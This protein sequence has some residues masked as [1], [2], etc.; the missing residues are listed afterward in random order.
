MSEAVTFVVPGPRIEAGGCG[1]PDGLKITVK[2]MLNNVDL[3][4]ASEA[5]VMG[6]LEGISR[7]SP[8]ALCDP[9]R[10]SAH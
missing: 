1:T 8:R 10:G 4:L 3:G 2:L 7:R 9:P 5:I 6:K